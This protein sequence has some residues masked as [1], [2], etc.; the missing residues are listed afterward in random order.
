MIRHYC[1]ALNRKTRRD[2]SEKRAI[3]QAFV[4][5]FTRGGGVRGVKR[6]IIW[7]FLSSLFCV[8]VTVKYCSDKHK[9][10]LRNNYT[11]RLIRGGEG[12][13]GSQTTPS[14]S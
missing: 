8:I 12:G 14:A 13:G 2:E 1:Q 10:S 9:H 6:M 4:N 7:A 11:L 5:R 3:T